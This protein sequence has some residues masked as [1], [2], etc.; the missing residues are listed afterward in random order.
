[1]PHLPCIHIWK[2]RH[3]QPVQNDWWSDCLI[4]SLVMKSPSMVFSTGISSIRIV[5]A[6]TIGPNYLKVLVIPQSR[7]PAL[8]CDQKEGSIYAA[9]YA[10]W[11]TLWSCKLLSDTCNWAKMCCGLSEV[12]DNRMTWLKLLWPGLFM[13]WEVQQPDT[14]RASS[15]M[16]PETDQHWYHHA[17]FLWIAYVRQNVSHT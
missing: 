12:I 8:V 17:P 1:M 14:S 10:N 6:S 5:D 16:I 11:V 2:F 13:N 9:D 15:S 3:N 4:I 7:T